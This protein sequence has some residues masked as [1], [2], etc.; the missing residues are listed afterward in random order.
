MIAV[1][2]ILYSLFQGSAESFQLCTNNLHKVCNLGIGVFLIRPSWAT[3]LLKYLVRVVPI[4]V[5]SV[6]HGV[7]APMLL[8][9]AE[10]IVGLMD[11]PLVGLL[12]NL[13]IGWL[14]FLFRVRPFCLVIARGFRIDLYISLEILQKQQKGLCVQRGGVVID[15]ILPP[16]MKKQPKCL[17]HRKALPP[18]KWSLPLCSS[19]SGGRTESKSISSWWFFPSGLTSTIQM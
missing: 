12:W 13:Q 7:C 18:T 14:H 9:E 15:V 10:V 3:G 19:Q 2:R 5:V 1:F 11:Q 17:F 6:M 16:C 4:A 8:A